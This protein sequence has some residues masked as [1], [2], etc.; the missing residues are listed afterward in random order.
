[1][2]P[3]VSRPFVRSLSVSRPMKACFSLILSAALGGA[4]I[5]AACAASPDGPVTAADLAAVAVAENAE[6]RFYEAEVGHL[7]ARGRLS[8]RMPRPEVSAEAGQIRSHNLDRTLAG[9]G[10]AWSVSVQQPFE[11]PGRLALR[12]AIANAET[13]LATLGLARFRRDLETR[14]HLLAVDLA[15]ADERGRVATEAAARFRALREVLVQRDPAGITPRLEIR[16]L[17]ATEL[18]L[19]RRVA[20]EE[21]AARRARIELNLLCGRPAESDLEVAGGPSGFLTA[22]P[23]AELMASAL[24]NNF[25]LQIRLAELEAQGFFLGLARNERWPQ[26]RVGPS[27]T[28]ENGSSRDRILTF[29]IQLP[30]PLWRDDGGSVEAARARE[31][32]AAAVLAV[33]R[34]DLEREVVTAVRTYE[35]R[36]A[37]LGRWH[38]DAMA[39][40]RSAADLADEHYRLGAVPA[41]TYVELQQ[42]YLE[43]VAALLET[44]RE[45]L[46]AALEVEHATGVALLRGPGPDATEE[47]P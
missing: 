22:P 25:D 44:R 35:A 6:L 34:R 43:A 16:I 13:G 9:E 30:L 4:A 1:M 39:E 14:V 21:L 27:Y 8:G 10:M 11:W 29:G 17:E 12:K 5:P 40:F 37:E 23:L 31:A 7:R 24:T 45:A 26:I 47:R 46:A 36:V 3:G 38:P 2:F 15:A 32:Q 41:T 42:Q 19:R 20:G 33:A 18:T 28:A